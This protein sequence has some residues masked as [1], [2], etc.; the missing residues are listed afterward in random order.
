MAENT[1]LKKKHR[2]KVDIFSIISS[3]RNLH[4]SVGKLQFPAPPTF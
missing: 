3:V 4:L 1:H 2:G